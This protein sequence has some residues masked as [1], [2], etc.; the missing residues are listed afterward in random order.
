MKVAPII[1]KQAKTIRLNRNVIILRAPSKNS[2]AIATVQIYF[3]I[4]T[5]LRPWSDFKLPD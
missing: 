1:A 2:A 4:L 5:G 3:A